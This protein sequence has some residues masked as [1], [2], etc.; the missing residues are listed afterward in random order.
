MYADDDFSY[1]IGQDDLRERFKQYQS[2]DDSG[3]EIGV[4]ESEECKLL[5]EMLNN[6]DCKLKLLKS[7]KYTKL[8][9]NVF[10]AAQSMK[11]MLDEIL[12]MKDKHQHREEENVQKKTD[13]E[14]EKDVEKSLKD[15]KQ[16]LDET[17]K[18]ELQLNSAEEMKE[19][20]VEV[21]AVVDLKGG[22]AGE[23]Y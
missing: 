6:L 10:A 1:E 22:R 7:V 23:L 21:D 8:D 3:Y 13:A 5:R 4:D 17:F 20:K 14:T 11:E 18:D 19:E 16:Q 9:A 12:K 15:D 2:Y